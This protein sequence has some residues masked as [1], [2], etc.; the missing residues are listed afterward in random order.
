MAWSQLVEA[1]LLVVGGLV[2]FGVWASARRRDRRVTAALRQSE[3]RFRQLTS[4]SADWFW[5]TDAQHR[6]SWLSVRNS[7]AAESFSGV[8]P[9]WTR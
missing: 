1:L 4:L 9:S 5:E 7:R 3:E 2:L 8:G 6:I